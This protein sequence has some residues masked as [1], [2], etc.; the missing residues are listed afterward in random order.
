MWVR[1]KE[2][3]VSENT[4]ASVREG[5]RRGTGGAVKLLC[6]VD[7]VLHSDLFSAYEFET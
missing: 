6:I 7:F 3:E 1:L 2:E 4:D 5:K